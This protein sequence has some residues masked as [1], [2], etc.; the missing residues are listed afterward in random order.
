MKLPN[1]SSA[2][3]AREKLRD[4]LLNLGHKR[5]GSKARLLLSMGYLAD[6]WE[7][8]E[9]DLRSQHLSAD[10]DATASS[11]YGQRLEIVADLTGPNGRILPFR[12]IWQIDIGTDVPRLITMYPE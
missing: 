12:S 7:R 4:Y 5:G 10:V 1:A 8:L 2:I 9:A 3:I 6:D 11:S